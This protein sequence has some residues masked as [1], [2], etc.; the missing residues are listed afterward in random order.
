[1]VGQ[2]LITFREVL[3]AALIVAIMLAYLR[4]TESHGFS[5]YVWAGVS[6]AIAS[7]LG[8]GLSIWFLYGGIPESAQ[9]LFE[10]CAA[11][12]AVAV[13][14]WMIFW[15]ATKGKEIRADIER[16][17]KAIATHGAVLGLA[18]L[19]FVV[20]FREGLETVLFLTP[21]MI[22]DAVATLT[23]AMLGMVSGLALGWVLF[24]LG[25]RI[26]LRKFFYFTSIL[27][28]LLA[29]GLFGYS[30]HE[31]VEYLK[32]TGVELGWVGEYAYV[33]NIAPD[34]VF[35]HK[36]AVGSIFAVM[37]GYTVKAEWARVTIHT[38]YLVIFLPFVIRLYRKQSIQSV[39]Q[40]G[41]A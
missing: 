12:L 33:L 38:A 9:Q 27:L 37:V 25:M 17:I 22:N 5:R 14:T 40:S 32:H 4:R 28:I 6:T 13:L 11:M 1:M 7:S 20:V 29:G 30:V 8:I 2:F 16:R 34:S 36:G 31:L 15:M 39:T 24:V 23:G 3:E 21:F 35:H 18:S 19:S 41:V 10:G 26:S